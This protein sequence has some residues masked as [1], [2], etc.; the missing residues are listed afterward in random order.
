VADPTLDDV[1]RSAAR[2]QRV[3]P[4]AVM[5]G[6]AAAALWAHH[7][8]SFDHD[9]VMADLAERYLEVLEAVE[10]TEGWVTSVRASSPPLTILGRLGGIEAGLR[11]LRRTR[12]LEVEQVRLDDE[13]VVVVPTLPE[14]LRV[15]AYLVVQRNQVRDY[16]DVVALAERMGREPAVGV[17]GAI[18]DYY[19]DRSGEQ[20]SVLTALVQRLA[21]PNPRDTVVTGQLASYRRLDPRW[22]DWAAVV[23]VCH[24]LSDALL[25]VVEE[26]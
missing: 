25:R 19:V 13:H 9:H 14:T 22:H 6:G 4:D 12:P 24:D 11:Q 20:D 26:R 8:D 16:L 18:D 1:L 15:K 7:R 21:E 5:V 17:L 23:Q 10:S 3:V 2:L